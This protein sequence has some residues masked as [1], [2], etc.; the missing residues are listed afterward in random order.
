MKN[1]VIK[2]FLE[3]DGYNGNYAAIFNEENNSF[4]WVNLD[5]FNSNK[6]GD[7]RNY[8]SFSTRE[9][10]LNYSK[11]YKKDAKPHTVNDILCRMDAG[12]R[13]AERRKR[14]MEER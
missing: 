11:H 1:K 7:F 9:Q 2:E 5:F 14:E 4:H 10:I 6:S 8:A 13:E 3:R 12:K